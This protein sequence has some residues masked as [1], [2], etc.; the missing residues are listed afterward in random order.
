MLVIKLGMKTHTL[1]VD[2]RDLKHA[3]LL[4]KMSVPILTPWSKF[5]VL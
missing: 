5:V 1:I 3:L 4:D 2:K